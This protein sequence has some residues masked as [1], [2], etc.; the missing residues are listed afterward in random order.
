MKKTV[1]LHAFL[2]LL[3]GLLEYQAYPDAR[4]LQLNIFF[5]LRMA[6][7]IST[8]YFNALFLYDR[9]FKRKSIA[10]GLFYL[11][12]S[13]ATFYFLLSRIFHVFYF[14]VYEERLKGIRSM[15]QKP[16]TAE[17]ISN[18]VAMIA[19][20]YYL[21]IFLAALFY[22]LYRRVKITSAR[23]ERLQREKLEKENE[24]IRFQ[25]MFLR[26]QI[27]PHFLHNTL[28]FFY[29]KALPLSPE[30]SEGILTLSN[31]MRY[32]LQQEEDEQGLVPLERE[33]EHLQNVISIHQ[34]RF[35]QRL[36]IDYVVHG[37]IE[38]A[39]VIP[40]VFITLLE[41]AFKHGEMLSDASPLTILLEAKEETG[42]V[43]FT[44]RNRKKNG[45]KEISHGIGIENIRQRLKN[46]YKDN[47]IFQIKNEGEVYE[48]EAELP[49][50]SMNKPNP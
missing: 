48:V 20:I 50:I 46:I 33:A 45:P 40:L 24:T 16:L 11:L 43:L 26:S 29:A 6:L 31:V 2:W 15:N 49:F 38:K 30:L 39:K 47:Y 28:N 5:L 19:A 27:N 41:N 42:R 35:S 1:A 13:A 4:V 34:M 8:F 9:L 22:W 17:Q 36:N 18:S 25:N 7:Y 10:Q 32:S 14:D 44:I 37:P 21:F 3:Y 12:I 23:A